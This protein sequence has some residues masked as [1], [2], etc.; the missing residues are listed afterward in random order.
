MKL[1][2]NLKDRG[3]QIKLAQT[4]FNAFIRER[5]KHQPCINCGSYTAT[6][7][8]A[9][10]FKTR[11]AYPELAFSEWNCFKECSQCNQHGFK[12]MAEYRA[13]LVE[14]IGLEKVE[15]LEGPHERLKLTIE[16]IINIKNTYQDKLKALQ[17]RD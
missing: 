16:E 15:W 12:G 11:G 8:D 3:Y 2:M 6:K 7:W 17:N 10:H 14:R 13:N 1:A 4:A 5:D 9:G